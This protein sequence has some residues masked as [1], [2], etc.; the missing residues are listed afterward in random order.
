[1][2]LYHNNGDGTFTEVSR[3]AGLGDIL[4]KG[5]G[6][7]LADFDGSGRPGLFIANDHAP[8]LLIRNMGGGKMQET[9]MEAGVAYNGDGREISGMGADFGDIDGD[10]RPDIVMTGLHGETFEVF[11]NHGD[12]TFEDASA[13]QRHPRTERECERLGLRAG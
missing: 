10:G 12:G 1:M 13:A 8:N 4:G 7:A 9:G 11:A 2:L 6:V 3:A 5:M